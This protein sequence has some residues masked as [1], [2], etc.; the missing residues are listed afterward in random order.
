MS[1][2]S[3]HQY[4]TEGDPRWEGTD[5]RGLA[6]DTDGQPRASPCSSA[7]Q[8][9]HHQPVGPEKSDGHASSDHSR[10][11]D[12]GCRGLWGVSESKNVLIH[13]CLLY[14]SG[15]TVEDQGSWD[16][17]SEYGVGAAAMRTGLHP[18]LSNLTKMCAGGRRG[19]GGWA[20][21]FLPSHCRPVSKFMNSLLLILKADTE[22]RRSFPKS[23]GGCTLPLSLP[24]VLAHG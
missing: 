20:S 2:P 19:G 13:S 11:S 16:R 14:F 1:C 4:F 5:E 21:R 17:L 22:G 6:K 12:V 10:T 18:P 15:K 7:P 9:P 8:F 3:P 24:A 23:A